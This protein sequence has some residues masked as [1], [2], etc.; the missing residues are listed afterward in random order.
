M[1][2]ERTKIAIIGGDYSGLELMALIKNEPLDSFKVAAL[3]DP[4]ENALLFKLT[5]YGYEF[6]DPPRAIF[7]QD[8]RTLEKID[9]LS[10][11]IDTT[12]NKEIHNALYKL[13]IPGIKILNRESGN[14]LFRM[15]IS[16]GPPDEKGEVNL[17]KKQMFI[18]QNFIGAANSISLAEYEDELYELFLTTA[19]E[20]TQAD[21]GSVMLLNKTREHLYLVAAKGLSR[22]Y[23]NAVGRFP[24]VGEG[25][26][27]RVAQIGEPLLL[28]G[29]FEDLRFARMEEKNEIKSSICVP[30]KLSNDVLGVLNVGSKKS[31]TTFSREDLVFLSQFSNLAA[32]YIMEIATHQEL[33]IT[34]LEQSLTKAVTQ[35]IS[36][37][38]PLKDKLQKAALEIANVF[39]LES[40]NLY[41]KESPADELTLRASTD[42]T[43][44]LFGILKLRELK[45]AI[46]RVFKTKKPIL[47]KEQSSYLMFGEEIE[48]GELREGGEAYQFILPLLHNDRLLGVMSVLFSERIDRSDYR[49]ALCQR[50]SETLSGT[51]HNQLE[52]ESQR[53][54]AIR[55]TTANEAG[56]SLVSIIDREKLSFTIAVSTVQLSDAEFAILR[57]YNKKE[58]KLPISSFYHRGGEM[59]SD[60]IKKYDGGLCLATFK[61]QAVE[62]EASLSTKL[63]S[64]KTAIAFPLI[65]EEEILGVL[66]A[67]NSQ[68]E[69]SFSPRP[70][71][72][73]DR[74]VLD[75]FAFYAAMS[76]R[77]L[78][79]FEERKQFSSVNEL[80]GMY[81]KKILEARLL[82]EVKRADRTQGKFSLLMFKIADL[83][84]L[85]VN[86]GI[87]KTQV[88][89]LVAY[90]IERHFR[91]SDIL[92]HIEDDVFAVLL[93]EI[94]M[95]VG[96]ALDRFRGYLARR[97]LRIRGLTKPLTLLTGFSSYPVNAFSPDELFSQSSQYNKGELTLGDVGTGIKGVSPF[98]HPE[99]ES[100]AGA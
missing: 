94:G 7:S 13:Q 64:V 9:G 81:T 63:A 23:I 27:G 85:D 16:A 55:L 73:S 8:L 20:A 26:S 47:L 75:K 14:F 17:A 71:T 66:S 90:E 78:R 22:G 42:I 15:R 49:L 41:L 52:T 1:T 83:A 10:L 29:K 80:T 93:P 79:D 19:M 69:E 11:I 51:I 6:V 95:Q 77:N 3:I 5:D 24:R 4:N 100:S 53:E 99:E 40:L 45:G 82:E 43:P 54:T 87:S 2:E 72:E 36:L 65:V 18:F 28:S 88:I 39:N 56:M 70:F 97:N 50:L 58:N 38:I 21:T 89:K 34:Q 86:I 62:T 96:E 32:K 76:L 31:T 84:S 92:F 98:S 30:I 59:L 46:G 35:I 48:K 68:D 12:D 25:I 37:S 74:I 61:S 67:Y 44:S 57:I 60:E 33:K 91:K